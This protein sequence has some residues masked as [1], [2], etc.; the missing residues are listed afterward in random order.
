MATLAD[1][2]RVFSAADAAQILAADHN[3]LQDILIGHLGALTVAVPM[4]SA[5]PDHSFAPLRW[6]Y[7]KA[8]GWWAWQNNTG[9]GDQL[10]VP[11]GTLRAGQVISAINVTTSGTSAAGSIILYRQPIA[12]PAAPTST[13]TWAANPFQTGAGVYVVKPATAGLPHT[14]LTDFEYYIECNAS[15]NDPQYVCGVEYTVQ[16]GT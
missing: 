10:V 5:S 3:Q 4:A 15:A 14:V 16:F 13:A 6:V 8:L 9:A 11:L 1:G 2:A 7:R 12:V